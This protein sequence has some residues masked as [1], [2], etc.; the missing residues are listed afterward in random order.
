MLAVA[1]GLS[2]F[3]HLLGMQV[4]VTGGL[5]FIGG[6]I[7]QA[8][9]AAGNAVRILDNR[10]PFYDLRLKDATAARLRETAAASGGTV[11][12]IDG[13]VRDAAQVRDACAGVDLV[14]H[15]AA[16]AGVR[17]S[18]EDPRTY[19][20]VNVTGTL[21]LLEA[22]R[23]EEP[24][25]L[26][27]AS[28]SS[29]YGGD[30]RLLPFSESDPTVPISPY[31]STKLAAD[32][33]ALTYADV[34]DLPVVV[35]RYFTVYGPRM[36]PNMAISN[37]VSRAFA[38]DALEIYGD[39]TQSRDF[40]YV[41]DVVDVNMQLAETAEAD[42]R[43]LNIGSGDRITIGELAGVIRDAID[44]AVPIEHR[45]AFAIDAP[46]TRAD[47]ARAAALLGYGPSYSIR[48]G[49]ET[50]IGWFTANRE[51]YAPLARAAT[52]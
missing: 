15:H 24:T 40:T 49:V 51:W 52:E 30:Q 33:Y 28:S 26:I 21:N 50:F 27:I 2:A 29:V 13:D 36:R 44:P 1:S 38:G 3:A 6:H 18:V 41:A 23:A 42:G 43:V 4:L 10:D 46:H 37:F 31:G 5:G 16:K 9:L 39:G 35:L 12:V 25:R 19:H 47:T 7:A 45:D 32:R 34:Y 20:D 17:P 11:E 22:A 14:Y 48:E 8:Q